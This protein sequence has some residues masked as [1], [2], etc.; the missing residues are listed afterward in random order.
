MGHTAGSSQ[1]RGHLLTAP[2]GDMPDPSPQHGSTDAMFGIVYQ[3]LRSIAESQMS[4][5][6]AGLTL[7]PTA[8]V[9]EVYLRLLSSKEATWENERHFFAA[10][11]EAMRR[12]LV[13]R[14]RR[15]SRR[16]HGGGRRRVGMDEAEEHAPDDGAE[17]DPEAM[18]GLDEAMTE[19]ARFDPVLAEV[20]MLRYFAGLTVEQT[21]A[22][23]GR[24]PRSVKSD[25]VAARAWLLRRIEGEREA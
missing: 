15:V 19:L 17:G 25:W 7:Q 11:A 10:A 8:L 4:N 20:A 24:S 16:R 13:E 5:E 21:A 14:A 9:H 1:I 22:M 12:I 3:Q 23:V 18:L 6:R 2:G